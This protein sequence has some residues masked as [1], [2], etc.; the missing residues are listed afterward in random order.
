MFEKMRT[1]PWP[2]ICIA[3]IG[4]ALVFT[5][6]TLPMAYSKPKEMP[7]AIVSL[8]Q[9]II[10]PEQ[11]AINM[12]QTIM[13]TITNGTTSNTQAI[14][15]WTILDSEEAVIAG[16]NKQEYY[17]ALII[18]ADYTVKALSLQNATPQR[19]NIN[20][21]VNQGKNNNAA[22]VCE[23]MLLGITNVLKTQMQSNILQAL[24]QSGQAISDIQSQVLINPIDVSVSYMN[25][26]GNNS[27]N[28]MG[29]SLIFIP[30][31]VASIAGAV[32]IYQLFG[33]FKENT[34][35]PSITKKYGLQIAA[36]LLGCLLAGFTVAF[37]GAVIMQLSFSFMTVALFLSLASFC[38]M[39]M[40]LA[41]LNWMD[42][43]GMAIFILILLM[44]MTLLNLPYEF[45]P[46][47]YQDWIYPWI[48]MRFTVEGLRDI[49]Y[50]G[51][52]I[53]NSATPVLLSIGAVSLAVLF[54]EMFKPKKNG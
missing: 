41:V 31:W 33:K 39:L 22:T 53:W 14:V 34:T 13:N 37:I 27:A 40:V 18:S 32:L 50:F 25:P 47:I 45:M 8:D 48:P 9:G 15:K 38:Y 11:G 21:I 49:F 51:A 19:P 54:L 24:Q 16:F 12:G 5:L 2:A 6:I 26:V 44:G 17:A 20:I 46:T 43:G 3:I 28:G 36:A 30:L 42:M 35:K 7:L 10:A 29:Q 1:R 52:G 4:L 23:T